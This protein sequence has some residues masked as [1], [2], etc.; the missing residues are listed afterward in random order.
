MDSLPVELL[1]KI[2]S[3]LS[4]SDVNRVADALSDHEDKNFYC[5]ALQR[6]CNRS[7]H[8]QVRER[9]PLAFQMEDKKRDRYREPLFYPIQRHEPLLHFNNLILAF[10]IRQDFEKLPFVSELVIYVNFWDPANWRYIAKIASSLEFLAIYVM[11]MNTTTFFLEEVDMRIFKALRGLKICIHSACERVTYEHLYSVAPIMQ[12]QNLSFLTFVAPRY[13]YWFDV[14]MVFSLPNLTFIEISDQMIHSPVKEYAQSIEVIWFSVLPEDYKSF[15]HFKD[16]RLYRNQSSSERL[17]DLEVFRFFPPNLKTILFQG[18][19]IPLHSLANALRFNQ[20]VEIIVDSAGSAFDRYGQPFR[21][22]LLQL[23]R[24][25]KFFTNGNRVVPHDLSIYGSDKFVW[26]LQHVFKYYNAQACTSL[27]KMYEV[28]RYPR[29]FFHSL[30]CFCCSGCGPCLEHRYHLDSFVREFSLSGESLDLYGEIKIDLNTHDDDDDDS[31][32]E[33][34]GD[35]IDIDEDEDT[36]D[37][38]MDEDLDIDEQNEIEFVFH[39][40]ENNLVDLVV[41]YH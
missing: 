15:R 18:R 37:A 4:L 36:D 10:P 19:I 31:S 14:E 22:V 41:E 3:F 16:L 38:E 7:P 13:M 24:I 1:N 28:L 35:E 12:M 9:L 20:N 5:E 2:G 34:S 6:D 21:P 29:P 27:K 39:D 32:L 23:E 30:P 26:R 40:E 8:W 25:N 11:V 17:P 33:F